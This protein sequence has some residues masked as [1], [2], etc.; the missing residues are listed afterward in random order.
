MTTV[1]ELYAGLAKTDLAT[2]TELLC[3]FV[4]EVTGNDILSPGRRCGHAIFNTL[5]NLQENNKHWF[6]LFIYPLLDTTG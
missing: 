6:K 2:V 4:T 1:T 5:I 3:R